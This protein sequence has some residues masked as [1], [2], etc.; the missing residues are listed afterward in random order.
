LAFHEAAGDQ[1]GG[2]DLR[3]AG[4]E[5]LGEVWEILGDGRGGYGSG[6]CWA[7]SSVLTT[8][9]GWAMMGGRRPSFSDVRRAT[10]SVSGSRQG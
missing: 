2:E 9:A 3:W 5:G 6:Y 7:F 1:L 4:E 8:A 10:Q